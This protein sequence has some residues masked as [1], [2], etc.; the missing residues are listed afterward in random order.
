MAGLF[1]YN[2]LK[3]INRVTEKYIQIAV[4]FVTFSLSLFL[5]IEIA[6]WLTEDI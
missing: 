1:I 6:C 5:A 2:D 4:T 3:G